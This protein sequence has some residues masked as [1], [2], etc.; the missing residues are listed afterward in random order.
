M[1]W[2]Q[3]W[4]LVWCLDLGRT[5][6]KYP[7]WEWHGVLIVVGAAFNVSPTPK[8]RLECVGVREASRTFW[9]P[10][11]RHIG[12]N[13]ILMVAEDH[14]SLNQGMFCEVFSPDSEAALMIWGKLGDCVAHHA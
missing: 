6:V 5:R 4:W 13:W 3:G 12:C 9:A 11:T 14:Y 10:P 2:W 8:M 1:G 7:C